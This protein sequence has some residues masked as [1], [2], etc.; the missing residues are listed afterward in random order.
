MHLYIDIYNYL[1]KI[2]QPLNAFNINLHA[3]NWYFIIVEE[4]P[5]Y[6]YLIKY[7]ID[8][9]QIEKKSLIFEM[10]NNNNNVIMKN[11]KFLL[12]AQTDALIK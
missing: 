11:V 1:R 4:R 10:N 3:I 12:H 6:V 9:M 7:L 8:V 5:R 2:I